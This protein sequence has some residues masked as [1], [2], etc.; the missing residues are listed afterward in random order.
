MFAFSFITTFPKSFK[1][2]MLPF[3]SIVAVAESENVSSSPW[4]TITPPCA[5]I[6]L[7]TVSYSWES[8]FITTTGSLFSEAIDC[9]LPSASMYFFIKETFIILAFISCFLLSFSWK[10]YGLSKN[11]AKEGLLVFGSKSSSAR[12]LTTVISPIVTFTSPS[13]YPFPVSTLM[14][15]L[16]ASITTFEA[17][18]AV[19]ANISKIANIAN[20]FIF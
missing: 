13:K 19:P 16:F 10:A 11:V 3:S 8:A 20:F 4:C 6:T 7:V 9:E 2:L 1:S 18:T 5:F 14:L 17:Y 15:C 12:G